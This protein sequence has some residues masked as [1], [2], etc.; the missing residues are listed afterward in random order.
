VIRAHLIQQAALVH[1]DR[2]EVMP[3][4]PEDSAA[5]LLPHGRT[6]SIPVR[7]SSGLR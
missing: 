7:A 6:A 1:I 3:V 5:T 2:N 4:P